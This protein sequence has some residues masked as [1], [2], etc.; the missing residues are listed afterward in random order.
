MTNHLQEKK[1]KRFL[2]SFGNSSLILD[3]GAGRKKTSPR[4]L[5]VDIYRA[6]GADLI[7]NICSMPVLDNSVDGVIARGVLEHVP[8]PGAVVAEMHRILKPG[9]R[10][11]SSVPFMQGYHPSPGDYQRYTMDGLQKLFADFHKLECGI[12]RGSASSF[13]WISREFF[14]QALSF[15]NDTISHLSKIAF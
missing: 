15:N 10:V 12:T 4:V 8:V 2:D 7:G 14:S 9:G 3:F 11:Y 6:P 1:L 5:S 13:I